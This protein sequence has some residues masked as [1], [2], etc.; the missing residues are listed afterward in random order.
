V[1]AWFAQLQ[2]YMDQEPLRNRGLLLIFNFHPTPIVAPSGYI[3]GRYLV[4]VINLCQQSASRTT[5]SIVIE[6]SSDES[7]FLRVRRNVVA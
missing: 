3:H 4:L 1:R 5:D 2:R 6:E 7:I